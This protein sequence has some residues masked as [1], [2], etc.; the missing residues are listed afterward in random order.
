LFGAFLCDTC[1]FVGFAVTQF[2]GCGT[3]TDGTVE[4]WG[5]PVVNSPSTL[6]SIRGGNAQFCGLKNDNTAYCWGADLG[7]TPNDTF[8]MIDAG[9]FA[10]CG[11]KQNGY[12]SCWGNNTLVTSNVPSGEFIYVDVGYNSACALTPSN[13]IACWGNSTVTTNAS[14]TGNDFIQVSSNTFHACALRSNGT[15]SCWGSGATYAIPNFLFASIAVGYGYTCGITINT[16]I[17]KCW[18]NSNDFYMLPR[19]SEVTSITVS[20]DWGN[21]CVLFKNQSVLCEKGTFPTN[22]THF[23]KNCYYSLTL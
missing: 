22:C 13:S 14:P 21:F 4:C 23:G 17:L 3:L 11:L 8:T 15:V 20:N 12:I 18:G 16:S 19:E 2:S 5:N 10:T 9:Y 7:P 6:K 1:D